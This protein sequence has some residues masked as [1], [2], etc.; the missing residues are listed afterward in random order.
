MCFY[1]T[2]PELSIICSVM[3][4]ARHNDTRLALMSPIKPG[5]IQ[6]AMAAL[7]LATAAV[8]LCYYCY[9]TNFRSVRLLGIWDMR[10]NERPKIKY[11]SKAVPPPIG[12]IDSMVHPDE[13]GEFKQQ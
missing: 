8:I 10:G 2:V 7:V 12:F 9:K 13:R 1:Y 5:D 6:A 3:P 4:T 11:F